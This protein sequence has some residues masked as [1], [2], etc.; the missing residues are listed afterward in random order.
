MQSATLFPGVA[1]FW[2]NSSTLSGD[3]LP[4][5]G[6]ACSPGTSIGDDSSI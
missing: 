2:M 5:K 4:V 3:G 6:S 1:T